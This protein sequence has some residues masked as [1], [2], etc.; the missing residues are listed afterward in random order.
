MERKV[1]CLQW[2]MG[3]VVHSRGGFSDDRQAQFASGK[4]KI[5]MLMHAHYLLIQFA[6]ISD[7]L[8]ARQHAMVFQEV[9]R[10]PFHQPLQ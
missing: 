5:N 3:Q 9:A 10:R 2:N 4:R 6:Q 1:S 7:K 8:R